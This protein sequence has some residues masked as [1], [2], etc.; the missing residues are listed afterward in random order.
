LVIILVCILGA[1]GLAVID[2]DVRAVFSN[3]ASAAVGGYFG[4][5]VPGEGIKK[6]ILG[7]DHHER[8]E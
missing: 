1:L 5:T 4:A 7:T 2:R 6:Q 8:S 3:M